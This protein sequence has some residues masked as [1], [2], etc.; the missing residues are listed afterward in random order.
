MPSTLSVGDI[1]VALTRRLFPAITT[2][3]RLEARPR[4]Q[5]FDRALRAE[6][7]DRVV[8]ADQAM[9]DGRVPGTRCRLASVREAVIW[10]DASYQVPGR[11]WRRTVARYGY[12]ARDKGRAAS[13]ADDAAEAR[14]LTGSA[15]G[16][17]SAV[18]RA[19]CRCRRLSRQLYKRLPDPRARSHAAAGC[20]YL[21]ASRGMGCIPGI[22]WTCNGR[23]CAAGIPAH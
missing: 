17:G 6:V 7:R 8:D 23:R 22:G 20:R 19:H 14:H 9:A 16:H 12:A 18:V 5:T 2:W 10:H 4:S 3:N 1:K 21:L 13:G 15:P 11:R